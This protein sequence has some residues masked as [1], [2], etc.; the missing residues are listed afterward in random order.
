M[1]ET[2][3]VVVVGAGLSGIGAACHLRRE[4]PDESVLVLEARDALGGT[5]DL[6]RYPGVR[7]DSSMF[8][9]AYDFAPWTGPTAI[10]EGADILAYLERTA[11]AYGVDERVRLGHRVV[12][13]AWS[14]VDARWRLTVAHDG[15]E[16]EVGCRFLWVCTGYYRYDGG[17]VP[18]LAGRDAFGG[19]FVHPQT[20]PTDLDVAGRDVVVIGSGA[21]AIT[22]V[23]ALAALGARVTM[24]QRSPS[25]V[26]SVP[27]LDPWH[28]RFARARGIGLQTGLYALSRRSPAL[29]RAWLLHGVTRRL[30]PGYDVRT[31]FT[32]RYDPWDQRLCVSPD[33]DLFTAISERRV[34]VVTATVDRLTA[35]GVRLTTGRELPADVVVTATG[36]ELLGL[37][38]L[39]LV[40]DGDA[41][42]PA[43]RLAWRGTM[44][45]GVPN[46]AVTLGYS[47][48][49]WTLRAD[50][51]ARFVTRLL[52]TLR[53][54][55]AVSATPVEPS[56][57]Q[58]RRP[59]FALR[60]GYVLRGADRLPSQGSRHPWVLG[61][62]PLRERLA[63]ALRRR[64]TGLRL[65][66]A[67]PGPDG[68][69]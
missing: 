5:W 12:R 63:F 53:R 2:Y 32:P 23:P 31:H 50:L 18:E 33:G 45:S 59:L 56:A 15:T 27:R 6:F 19:R 62:D 30:P 57:P 55:G 26:A 49:S 36:L 58:R 11:A 61:Q 67:R 37:G 8:T 24:V 40:V 65:V 20:W 54:R 1:D 28:G 64:T 44:L 41:V 68:P 25:Y 14:G 29:V 39:E 4:C 60:S 66:P 13:A 47:A 16:S 7:S 38:G 35:N 10:A 48:A 52:Q 34:E 9:L 17:H 51:V 43:D 69:R 3:D 21:T 42:D 46:L 22:L